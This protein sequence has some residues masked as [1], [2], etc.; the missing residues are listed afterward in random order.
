MIQL[1][2]DVWGC[3]KK[4]AA[5]EVFW[6]SMDFLRYE[7]YIDSYAELSGNHERQYCV[8]NRLSRTAFRQ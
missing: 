4:M 2:L 6:R 1:N 7:R 3:S 8:V 5:I